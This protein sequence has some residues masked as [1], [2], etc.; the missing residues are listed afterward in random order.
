MVMAC[1]H[2]SNSIGRYAVGV[3]CPFYDEPVIIG[4]WY[5]IARIHVAGFIETIRLESEQN[6]F[7]KRQ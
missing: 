5:F 2:S 4:H 6:H 7:D 3:L 1:W